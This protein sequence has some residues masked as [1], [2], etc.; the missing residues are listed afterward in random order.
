MS[1]V[2]SVRQIVIAIALGLALSTATWV[3]T[4]ESR[5]TTCATAGAIRPARLASNGWPAVW[6][7]QPSCGTTEINDAGLLIDI[8]FWSV[9]TGAVMFTVAYARRPSSGAVSA[10]PPEG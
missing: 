6:W 9:L 10:L 4:R 7:R 8:V 3:I 1:G 5:P 2:L